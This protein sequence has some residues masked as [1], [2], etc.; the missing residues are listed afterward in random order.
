MKL[1]RINRSRNLTFQEIEEIKNL[2]INGAS[3]SFL[4]EKYIKDLATIHRLLNKIFQKDELELIKENK[5]SGNIKK[6]KNGE[7][8]KLCNE[9]VSKEEFLEAITSGVKEAILTMTE[10]GDGFD[11]II[12]REPFLEAIRQG[13]KDAMWQLCTNATDM[14]CTDFYEMIKQGTKE[15]IENC[16]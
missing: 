16:N 7:N 3:I 8:M 14:P 13:V 11:G 1:R 15:G 4:S 2:Y 10:T 5:K 9:N 6:S 12:I